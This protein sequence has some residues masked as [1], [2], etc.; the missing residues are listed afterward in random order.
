MAFNKPK[1]LQ[2][3]QKHVAQGKLSQAIKAYQEIFQKDSTDLNL[4][5]TIGDLY[6]RE[7]AVGKA[8]EFF[9]RLAD[10]YVQDSFTVKAIAIY[11][12]IS[13]LDTN[14]V[15]PL[16]KLAELYQRQG[17]GREAREQYA[18]AV[19]FFK[20]K[21]QG[22]KALELLRNVCRLDPDNPSFRFQV[23]DLCESLGR[24]ADA[25]QACLEGA[26]IAFR[27]KDLPTAEAAVRRAGDFGLQAPRL[28][29]LRARLALTRQE[30]SQAESILHS[31]P[32]LKTMPEG[33]QLLLEA[34]MAS[35]K[36]EEAQ[37]LVLEV[38]QADPAD[39]SPLA[40]FSALC[41]E[42]GNLTAALKPLSAV[43]D[44]LIQ[45]RNAAP[46]MESLRQM[47]SK[48]PHE[49]PLLELIYHVADRSG[50][51]FTLPEV[52]EGLGHAYVQAGALEKAEDAYRKLTHRE[53]E[54]EHYRGLLKQVLQKQ[55]KELTAETTAS[56]TDTEMA[57]DEPAAAAPAAPVTA[58]EEAA[59][60]NSALENSDLFSQ[61]GL[62]DKAVGELEKV[63][64]VYPDQVD[65]HRR[66]FQVCQRNQ[67]E[68]AAQAAKALSRIYSQR[69]DLARA[70]QYEEQARHPEIPLTDEEPAKPMAGGEIEVP[71]AP[72]PVEAAALEINLSTG[73]GVPEEAAPPEIPLESTVAPPSSETAA[74]AAEAHE[75]DLSGDWEATAAVAPR[76]A[77]KPPEPVPLFHYEEA[78]T[79]INFYL[80]NGF[81]EEAWKTVQSL[82]EKF[83][84]NPQVAELRQLVESHVS[85]PATEAAAPPA[86]SSQAPA[87]EAPETVLAGGH[88]EE[89]SPTPPEFPA[90]APPPVEPSIPPSAQETV[91]TGATLPGAEVAAVSGANLLGDLASE[92]AGS[93]EGLEESAPPASPPPPSPVP[94]KA[95]EAAAEPLSLLSGMLDELSEPASKQAAQDDP[96]THY[97]LGVAFREMGLLDEAIGEFQKVVKG[98]QK[99]MFPPNFLQAC[100]LLASCFMDKS[101][102][103]VAAKWYVRA[104]EMP[105]LDEESVLAL[106][107]DLGVAYEL[108]GDTRTAL[109][110]FTEV[111]GQNIDFRDVAE[112]IRSLQQKAP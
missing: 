29:L 83:H 32:G 77:A 19:E 18:Q 80:E 73:L 79:E 10:A 9:H 25:G 26:E 63:L 67:P 22:D 11:K 112:K 99:G 72:P 60:V 87:K 102:P 66:I 93:L 27:R 45:K 2:E 47:W 7:R 88:E 53:P 51:E 86:A 36:L 91:A 106:Q 5:N 105:N 70:K 61:Y 103:G 78:R 6:V 101:M 21:N 81:V 13:K 40:H 96:E 85:A 41:I 1:A 65:I 50:D 38:Y 90:A 92:L 35:Q 43:A 34:Y 84:G 31:V 49:I 110:K 74:P 20:K 28:H 30:P 98:A 24:K 55:G 76:E 109:E 15:E 54:N 44:E 111:Y 48:Y 14:A 64:V 62:M 107:Y 89:E 4:L 68:R 39:F 42:K 97:N 12:K 8:L 71:L 37:G 82:E 46:L 52:L 59:L 3:A 100:T 104:L 33:R 17:L 58:A 23:A 95:A 75:F 16:L 57:L 69:G 56:L 94:A 108:A